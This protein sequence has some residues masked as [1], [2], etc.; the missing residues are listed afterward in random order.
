[1]VASL[2]YLDAFVK[3]GG[4][5]RFAERHLYVNWVETRAMGSAPPP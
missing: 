5:W 2:R 3:Q 1:M 4:T